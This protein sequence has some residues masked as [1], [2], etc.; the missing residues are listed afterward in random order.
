MSPPVVLERRHRPS[1]T[2]GADRVNPSLCA[3]RLG[4]GRTDGA[5][6]RVALRCERGDGGDPARYFLHGAGS[7]YM[8]VQHLGSAKS[9]DDN[10]L[11]LARALNNLP[12][13]HRSASIATYGFSM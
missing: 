9:R 2:S 6:P 4:A 11:A 7:P 8:A 10:G 1:A 5:A 3:G 13:R 12:A